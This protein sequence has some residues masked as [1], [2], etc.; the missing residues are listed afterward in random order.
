MLM[1]HLNQ[2]N[3]VIKAGADLVRVSV[4]DKESSLALKEITKHSAGSNNS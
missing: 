2:I 4:P 1:L 3:R